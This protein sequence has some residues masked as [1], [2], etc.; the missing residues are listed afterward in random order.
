[1]SGSRQAD[2]HDSKEEKLVDISDC[3]PNTSS[4]SQNMLDIYDR[5]LKMEQDGVARLGISGSD[6]FLPPL[7]FTEEDKEGH[8]DESSDDGEP[9]PNQKRLLVIE[10]IK[11]KSGNFEELMK[12]LAVSP[13]HSLDEDRDADD[14][15]DDMAAHRI[16][17]VAA[18]FG[19]SEEDVYSAL[20]SL[21]LS[22]GAKRKPHATSAY[23]TTLSLPN[24][25]DRHTVQQITKERQE[26]DEEQ[27]KTAA[28]PP[29]SIA[30]DDASDSSNTEVYVL[31]EG[32]GEKMQS[33]LEEGSAVDQRLCALLGELGLSH[34]MEAFV[35]EEW[36]WDGV[37]EITEEDLKELGLKAGAR[38]KLMT[39]IKR[40]RK[41]HQD[42]I[43]SSSRYEV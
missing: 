37:L 30:V 4:T 9:G 22:D 39:A 21:S 3:E 25:V 28:M 19:V 8:E 1:M 35:E 38:R 23:T 6:N 31:Q 42:E 18:T 33:T 41:R 16:N 15:F 43:L 17:E 5:Q 13:N 32:D 10:S 7:D 29:E 12:H 11:N 27:L 14:M 26:V 2:S 20:T 40:A 36:D 34:Y 24:S